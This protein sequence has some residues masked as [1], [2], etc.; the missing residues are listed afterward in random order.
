M[1]NTSTTTSNYFK[2]PYTEA[3]EQVKFYVEMKESLATIN[4]YKET[5]TGKKNVINMIKSFKCFQITIINIMH[6]YTELKNFGVK[7]IYTRRL[8]QDCL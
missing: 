4:A 8:N 3:E 2:K 6:M 1:L 5:A 7:E